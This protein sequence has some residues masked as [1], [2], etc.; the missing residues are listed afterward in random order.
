VIFVDT[1]VVSEHLSKSP[2]PQVIAW[3]KRHDAH[4]ALA[5]ITIAEISYGIQ[6]LAPDQRPARLERG[7]VEWRTRFADR[8]FGFTEDAALAYGEILGDARRRGRAM[9]A[10]DGMIAAIARVNGGGLATRNLDDFRTTGLDLVSP[11][12]F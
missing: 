1:N 4:L 12:E 6:K 3:L 2:P 8:I 10:Q 11:W 5:T 7:L 9:S